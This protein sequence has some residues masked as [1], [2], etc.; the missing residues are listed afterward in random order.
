MYVTLQWAS[1]CGLIINSSGFLRV[2]NVYPILVSVNTIYCFHNHDKYLTFLWY[3]WF[4]R[5]VPEK[6]S[7]NFQRIHSSIK[8]QLEVMYHCDNTLVYIL[9]T[10]N[11]APKI[12]K[13]HIAHCNCKSKRRV[14]F[15]EN[16]YII[17]SEEDIK[18]LLEG[19]D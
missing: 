6:R 4:V 7:T 11:R 10:I 13:L 17:S 14:C 1:C 9:C 15:I 19:E 16:K 5:N 2:N 18:D 8:F 12:F 3:F